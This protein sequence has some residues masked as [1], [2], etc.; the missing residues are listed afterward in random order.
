MEV[1]F[2]VVESTAVY[3][4]ATTSQSTTHKHASALEKTLA[5]GS[6][7]GV[8]VTLHGH[9]Y[10]PPRENP[11]LDTA[12]H[13]SITGMNEF[14]TSVI[15]PMRL[16]AFSMKR[17]RWLRLSTIMSTSVSILAQR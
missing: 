4:D 14:T 3:N 13:R 6:A 8:Y 7:H 17:A 1:Q 2:N 16:P 12:R 11:Y 10:Q 9:F 5:R 15:V